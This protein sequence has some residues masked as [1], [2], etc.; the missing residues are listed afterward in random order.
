MSGEKGID[1][2]KDEEVEYDF[3]RAL[4]EGRKRGEEWLEKP[5]RK[6]MM[7]AL[8]LAIAV[9]AIYFLDQETLRWIRKI[10][11]WLL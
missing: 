9:A 3:D 7:Y 8:G 4:E 10:L 2:T 1:E 11:A 6:L 5:G